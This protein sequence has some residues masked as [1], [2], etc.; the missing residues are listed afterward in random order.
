MPLIRKTLGAAAVTVPRS[1]LLAMP[2]ATA[3]TL[4]GPMLTLPWM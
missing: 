4:P 2:L 3:N 1:E